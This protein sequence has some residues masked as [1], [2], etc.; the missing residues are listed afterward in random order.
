MR[1]AD[2]ASSEPATALSAHALLQRTHVTLASR[3]TISSSFTPGTTRPASTTCPTARC[4]VRGAISDVK[5]PGLYVDNDD[6]PLEIH[7]MHVRVAGSGARSGDHRCSGGVRDPPTRDLPDGHHALPEP[8]RAQGGPPASRT[9]CGSCSVDRVAAR[10][11]PRSFRRWRRRWSRAPGRCRFG[12][13]G[14][15]GCRPVREP[16]TTRPGPQRFA[17]NINTCHVWDEAGDHVADLR[18]GAMPP[19]PLPVTE[20]MVQ[21]GRNPAEW[22]LE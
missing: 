9:R 12:P 4:W 5:P 8:G 15:P 1:E 14:R 21:L 19:P 18:A 10:T 3:R 20:R 7:Q 11:P 22:R 13:C 16:T 17:G 6:E 2:G